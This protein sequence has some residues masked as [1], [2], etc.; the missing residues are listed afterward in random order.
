MQQAPPTP[1]TKP[2]SPIQTATIRAVRWL[3]KPPPPAS[4]KK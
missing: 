4:P 2:A 3:V 1:K